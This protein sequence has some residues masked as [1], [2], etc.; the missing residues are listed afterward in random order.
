MHAVARPGATLGSNRGIRV[1][2]NSLM[3]DINVR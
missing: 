3:P 1:N 2:T